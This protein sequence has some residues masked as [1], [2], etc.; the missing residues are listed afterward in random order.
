MGEVEERGEVGGDIRS[1]GRCERSRNCG[2]RR[3]WR[4]LEKRGWMEEVREVGEV[5]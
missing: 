1:G 3:K 2:G 4:Q 5:E